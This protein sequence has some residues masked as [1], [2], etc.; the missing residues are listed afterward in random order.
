MRGKGS[1]SGDDSLE[2]YF[3]DDASVVG[4]ITGALAT[5][6]RTGFGPWR[7]SL[8]TLDALSVFVSKTGLIRLA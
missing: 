6:D 8:R 4:V 5:R 2:E 3:G 1:R 7:L